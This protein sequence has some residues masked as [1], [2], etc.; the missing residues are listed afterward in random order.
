MQ[1]CDQFTR[2]D[3]ILDRP[4]AGADPWGSTWI[5]NHSRPGWWYEEH[6]GVLAWEVPVEQET[7]QAA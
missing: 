4:G 1:L 2:F 5:K 3:I 6:T 7:D